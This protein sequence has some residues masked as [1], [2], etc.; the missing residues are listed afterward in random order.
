MSKSQKSSLMNSNVW[1]ILHSVLWCFL[2]S[3]LIVIR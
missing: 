2:I 3:D 1:N